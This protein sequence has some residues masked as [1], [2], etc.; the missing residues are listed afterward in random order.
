[1]FLDLDKLSNW[2]NDFYHG[3][4]WIRRIEPG[5]FIGLNCAVGL[6]ANHDVFTG[7]IPRKDLKWVVF[8]SKKFYIIVDYYN[9][10]YNN[11]KYSHLELEDAKDKIDKFLLDLEKLRVFI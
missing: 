6:I 9:K 5:D 8:G 4:N 2:K 10:T 1:M 3:Q 11:P 7:K